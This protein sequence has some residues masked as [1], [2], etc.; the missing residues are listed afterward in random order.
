MADQQ[1]NFNAL[2]TVRVP[3]ELEDLVKQ[4]LKSL[5]EYMELFVAA[6]A[7]SDFKQIAQ[8]AH[9]IKGC[10]GSYGFDELSILGGNLETNALT[11]DSDQV[12][13]YIEDYV[14]YIQNVKIDFEQ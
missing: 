1:V 11:A 8:I 13:K 14:F 6:Y 3:N 4:Y 2:K 5:H 9:K 10:A 7:K 12:K